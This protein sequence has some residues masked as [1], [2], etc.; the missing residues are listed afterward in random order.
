LRERL[1]R[2]IAEMKQQRRPLALLHV[3]VS[4]FR[5]INETL[6]HLEGD[7][8]LQETA[9]RLA[10]ARPRKWSTSWS[11]RPLLGYYHFEI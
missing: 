1:E 10:K 11:R 4:R 7:K 5:E 6:G 9:S 8:F 2:G 3:R